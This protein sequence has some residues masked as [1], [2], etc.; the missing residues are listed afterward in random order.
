[1]SVDFAAAFFVVFAAGASEAFFAG[2][3]LAAG[4]S[5][6]FF[7]AAFF[8]AGGGAATASYFSGALAAAAFVSF[9]ASAAAFFET[10][11]T[12]MTSRPSDTT[13]VM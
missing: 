1:M 11:F 5:A 9:E 8:A 2:A 6:D 7:A 12:A 4:A 13:T 3:F 10:G